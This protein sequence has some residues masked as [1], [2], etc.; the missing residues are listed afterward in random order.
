LEGLA[1]RYWKQI[2]ITCFLNAMHLER[3][4]HMHWRR[5]SGSEDN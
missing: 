5:I 1:K 2:N 4:W 3:V